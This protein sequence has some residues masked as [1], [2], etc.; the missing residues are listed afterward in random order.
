MNELKDYL[1]DPEAMSVP[2]IIYII[3]NKITTAIYVGSTI[4]LSARKDK[5]ISQLK[6]NKHK[7]IH[8]QNAWNKYGE[9]QFEFV[10]VDRV[11]LEDLLIAEQFY[12]D[13]FN[14]E[15][16]MF[17][18]SEFTDNAF[19]GAKHSSETKARI[20]EKLKGN[21]Y[22]LGISHTPE[23]KE[24]L[25]ELSL[26]RGC[27]PPSPLG[28][29]RSEETKEKMRKPKSPEHIANMVKAHQKKRE[30]KQNEQS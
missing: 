3:T 1:N 2:G 6:N 12:Y 21:K 8:L 11:S 4:N 24:K 27:K 14:K 25:R 10:I 9:N 26:K 30:H 29:K 16:E 15:V 19:R 13:I 23:I 18:Y 7:N 22:R 20:S 5:H 28:V 17:N